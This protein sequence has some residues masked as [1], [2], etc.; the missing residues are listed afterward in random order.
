LGSPT[1]NAA[2]RSDESERSTLPGRERSLDG[3]VER[4]ARTLLFIPRFE[5]TSSRRVMLALRDAL[6]TA[7]GYTL[8]LE[9]PGSTSDVV[10]DIVV[11]RE[12]ISHTSPASKDTGARAAGLARTMLESVDAGFC[13]I[14][15]G[16]DSYLTSD[17][18]RLIDTVLEGA[19][20]VVLGA[21]WRTHRPF[22]RGGRWSGPFL[23]LRKLFPGSARRGALSGLFLVEGASPSSAQAS[24]F[25]AG[26]D[27]SSL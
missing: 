20:Q 14:L 6:T 21:V 19:S 18:Q 12:P 27:L 23:W 24:Y 3:R 4:P 16:S 7:G 8:E 2:N 22:A 25:V 11:F 15:D 9:G 26:K 10:V 17:P 5:L 13:M 1:P